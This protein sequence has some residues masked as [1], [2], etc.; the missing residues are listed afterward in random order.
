MANANRCW[1]RHGGASVGYNPPFRL[2]FKR[3]HPGG[4]SIKSGDP[5]IMYLWRSLVNNCGMCGRGE[6]HHSWNNW[7]CCMV[8]EG[9]SKAC[10]N[11]KKRKSHFI[12]SLPLWCTTLRT[13]SVLLLARAAKRGKGGLNSSSASVLSPNLYGALSDI[14]FSA[15]WR[16]GAGTAHG[17]V[18]GYVFLA[19]TGSGQHCAT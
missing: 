17:W 13:S 11:K 5:I 18:L 7:E 3:L 2:Q 4:S 14:F 15:T 1:F 16:T 19:W 10:L 8:I 12:N 9:L 6:R